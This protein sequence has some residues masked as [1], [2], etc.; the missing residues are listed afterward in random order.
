[1]TRVKTFMFYWVHSVYGPGPE[2]SMTGHLAGKVDIFMDNFCANL[3][4]LLSS[5]IQSVAVKVFG[6]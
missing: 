6:R 4:R 3:A 1:M 2:D 5:V